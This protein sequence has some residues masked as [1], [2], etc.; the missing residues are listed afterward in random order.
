M[1]TALATLRDPAVA[2][3]A[4]ERMAGG[5]SASEV[6]G[7]HAATARR[8]PMIQSR[9]GLDV[10]GRFDAQFTSPE[11]AAHFALMDAMSIDA[12]ASCSVRRVL[13]MKCRYEY[14]NNGF[15]MGLVDT[16]ANYVISTGPRLQVLTQDKDL[17][18]RIEELWWQWSEEIDLAETLRGSCKAKCYNG[19]GFCLLR[20]NPNLDNPVKLDVVPIEADQVTTPM[21]PLTAEYPDQYFDGVV[22]DRYGRPEIYHVLRQHPG[23][24]GLLMALGTEFD[25]WPAQCVVHDF[26]S[27]RPG[28]Q[29]GIPRFLPALPNFAN[30]RRY[31]LAVLAAAET[32][33][34]WAVTVE[35]NAPANAVDEY[36]N[37]VGA[38][39]DEL[40]ETWDLSPR[41]ANLMPDGYTAKQLKPEQPTQQHEMLVNQQLSEI[42]RCINMPLFVVSMDARQ[43]NMSSAYVAMQPMAK[44]IKVER[45]G[46]ERR[47]N[48]RIF[49]QFVR[50]CELLGLVPAGM[51]LPHGWQW[52]RINDHADPAKTASAA[53]TRLERGISSIPLECADMG[54]DWE[55]QQ[56]LAA[57]ALG[58]TVEQYR[59]MLWQ[60]MQAAGSAPMDARGDSRRDGRDPNFYDDKEDLES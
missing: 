24:F 17:N 7:R 1:T 57:K 43:A 35:T 2:A 58:V 12:A 19:E 60:R 45:R 8:W 40:T 41:M 16:L 33:A 38:S 5:R 46:Y 14:H 30:L 32:A 31:N 10:R 6:A 21:L 53:A 54:L 36:G 29:R 22:L 9:R 34:D 56:E 28:Q 4:L 11:S 55:E 25:A 18:D 50:E 20:S 15:F 59:R 26:E 44:A 47:L 52:D 23:A 51:P 49:P 42:G 37:P 27:V 13:R 3:S 48:T 39:G